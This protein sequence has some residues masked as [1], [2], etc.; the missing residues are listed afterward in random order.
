M[1]SKDEKKIDIVGLRSL[2]KNLVALQNYGMICP[3]MQVSYV[4]A[5]RDILQILDVSIAKGE[6]EKNEEKNNRNSDW[7]NEE[8]PAR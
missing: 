2:T 5:S 4:Y 6:L 3:K 1:F 7:W 8:I